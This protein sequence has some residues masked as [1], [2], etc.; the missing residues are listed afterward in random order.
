MALKEHFK[1]H[2]HPVKVLI[3]LAGFTV[4]SLLFGLFVMWLWNWLMPEIFGLGLIS[5]WQAWGLVLLSHIL[6][7]SGH[8]KLHRHR[9]PHMH[10][11]EW[12][13]K[14]ME[15]MHR[16]HDQEEAGDDQD[17]ESDSGSDQ[18]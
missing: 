6:F 12:R 17:H 8:H 2:F 16:F 4:L 7:K 1:R 13:A 9:P 14:F 11:K 5:Y 18:E 3:G 15:K 10:N